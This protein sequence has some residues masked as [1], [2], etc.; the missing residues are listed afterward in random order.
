MKNISLNSIR[1]LFFALTSAVL[2]MSCSSEKRETLTSGTF[3]MITSEDLFPVIDIQATDFQRMYDQVT[4][5]NISASTR[6]A[7][8][9]LLNDSIKLVVCARPLNN[10][11]RTVAVKNEFEIDSVK[12]AYDGVAVIVNEKNALTRLTTVELK[13]ILT[14]ATGRWSAVKGS[15]L[16]SA[17][18]IAMGDPNSGVHEFMKTRVAGDVPLSNTV[19]SCANTPEVLALVN[20]RPNAI[21]CIGTAWLSKLPQ[22]VR[23]LEIGDPQ[24]RRDS[25]STTMEYFQPHQAYIYQ[26]YY[27]LTRTIYIYSLNVGKGPGLG[28]TSFAAS[29]DGQKIIVSNGLVPATMPVRLVQLNTP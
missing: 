27:P 5:N 14:G 8:V 29:S 17:V 2:V 1:R 16:S 3:T 12:I 11:E 18:V 13:D 4:I 9:Q 7:F 28:F 25:T 22:G 10:E 23:V 24:F 19:V 15:R 21:G 20:D 26:R 6:E